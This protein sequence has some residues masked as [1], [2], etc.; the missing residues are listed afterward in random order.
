MVDISGSKVVV[1][2]NRDGKGGDWRKEELPQ[3]DHKWK[4]T[5]RSKR[6]IWILDRKGFVLPLIGRSVR[7]RSGIA[8]PFGQGKTTPFALVD[9]AR[10]VTAIVPNRSRMWSTEASRAACVGVA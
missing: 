4:A 1:L 2:W 3:N 9:V 7:D 8:L 10:A 6:G 5:T